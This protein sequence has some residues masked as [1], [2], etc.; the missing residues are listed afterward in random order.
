MML[1]STLVILTYSIYH[2]TLLLGVIL[3]VNAKF[4]HQTNLRLA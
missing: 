3:T 4:P 1:N 2:G